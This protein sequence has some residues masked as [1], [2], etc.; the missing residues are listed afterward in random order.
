[1]SDQEHPPLE[2]NQYNVPKQVRDF[3][4]LIGSKGGKAGSAEKKRR[5][6][7]IS[8]LKRWAQRPRCPVCLRVLDSRLIEKM[9]IRPVYFGVPKTKEHFEEL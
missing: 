2:V 5:A 4:R 3:F 1:M 6:G 7:R 8:A 9:E